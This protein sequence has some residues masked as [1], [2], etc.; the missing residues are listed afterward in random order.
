MMNNSCIKN[1]QMRG[2][3][4]IEILVAL[5]IVA[6]ALSAAIRSVNA[7]SINAI[8]LKEKSFAHWV[9]MNEV[10]EHQ[11]KEFSAESDEWKSVEMANRVW[12]VNTK[13]VATD[14]KSLFRIET[15]VF[16]QRED[17]SF[18]ASS[19]YFVGAKP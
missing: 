16:K 11:V 9:A 19:I 1:A 18:L 10:A 4:L 2:M 15:R 7:G 5:V 6:V 14:T 12:Y 3:T 13:V 8:H 17:D